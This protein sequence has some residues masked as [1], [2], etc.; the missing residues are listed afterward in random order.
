MTFIL[1]TDQRIRA[2]Y[3]SS[4]TNYPYDSQVTELQIQSRD[5]SK[6]FVEINT[7]SMNKAY[8]LHED[9]KEMEPTD[10]LKIMQNE[11]FATR[12]VSNARK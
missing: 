12:N 8:G 6:V 3:T 4:A 9:D 7:N 1:N 11:L 5:Y 2:A 10:Q